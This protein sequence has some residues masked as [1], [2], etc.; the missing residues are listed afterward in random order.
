MIVDPPRT[1][2]E[3]VVRRALIERKPPRIIA[4]SCDP[5][6]GARDV[7]ELVGAGYRLERM[8]ALD[9]F[10]VTA[11]VETVSVLRPAND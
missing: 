10:P 1:G 9:L 6:T 2:M 3:K 8:A 11:H 4:V 5:A 7:A